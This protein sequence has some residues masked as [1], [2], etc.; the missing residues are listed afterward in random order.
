MTKILSW[1]VAGL[2]AAHKKGFLEWLRKED[3]DILCLQETK[4]RPE[5]LPEALRSVLGYR[6]YFHSAEKPG[7][8]GVAVYTK[9]APVSVNRVLGEA[10][11][12]SEGRMLELDF[13]EFV[14]FNVYFPNAGRELSRLAYKLDFNELL[15]KQMQKHRNVVLA[16]DL[17]VAHKAIDL[18]RP[19]SNEGSPGFTKEERAFA[20]RLVQSSYI[21]T[22]RVFNKEPGHYTFWDMFTRARE[23]NVGWR[24]DYFFVSSSLKSLVK[25]AFIMPE[26]MGSDHCPVGVEIASQIQSRL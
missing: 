9:K 25:R 7:Y 24:I 4:A 15:F 17:N 10:R 1:N 16:G 26:V 3:P 5:Q 2:R 19:D 22:F 11:F 12:D 18:A 13:G 23:R 6:V 14:L 20:D 8:S 21:D